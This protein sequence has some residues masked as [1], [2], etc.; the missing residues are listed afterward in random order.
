MI[1]ADEKSDEKV[2]DETSNEQPDTT[3]IPDLEIE[4][5]GEQRS[6][7]KRQGLRILTPKQMLSR[8]LISLAQLKAGNN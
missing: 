5:S 8:P 1:K 3:D 4:E 6:N 7:Q 2:D